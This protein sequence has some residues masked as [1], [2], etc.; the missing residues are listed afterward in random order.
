M[1]GG[2]WHEYG[3]LE[4]GPVVVACPECL[5]LIPDDDEGANRGDH[6]DWHA[7]LQS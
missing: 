3:R 7:E 4:N 5:A 1:K 2:R 6:A